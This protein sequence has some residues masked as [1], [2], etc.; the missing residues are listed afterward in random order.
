MRRMHSRD[1]ATASSSS[2]SQFLGGRKDDDAS[3]PSSIQTHT[4]CRSAS[5]IPR[6]WGA[7]GRRGSQAEPPI[8]VSNFCMYFE[9]GSEIERR[10]RKGSLLTCSLLSPFPLKVGTKKNDYL[11]TDQRKP[12][13][14]IPTPSTARCGPT[15]RQERSDSRRRFHC[16][17]LLKLKKSNIFNGV[18]ILLF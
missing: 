1:G 16:T 17:K 11:Q 18:T 2:G 9:V 6:G 8:S 10:M 5:S 7:G 3:G 12:G 14:P 13:T 4:T 15:V